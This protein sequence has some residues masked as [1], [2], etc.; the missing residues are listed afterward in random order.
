MKTKPEQLQRQLSGAPHPVYMVVGDEPL[1]Q[2]ESADMIRGFLLG[3]GYSEREVMHVEASFDWNT[4]LESGNALSLFAEKKIIELRLPQAKL[5][6]KASEALTAYLENPSPDNTLVIIAGKL[7]SAAKK[8]AWFKRIDTMGLIVEIWPVELNQLD[9]WIQKRAQSLG[10]SLEQDAIALLSDRVEGNLLAAKQEL[11]KLNL[12]YPNQTLSSDHIVDAVSDSSRYD[13]YGLTEAALMGD[14]QRCQKVIHVLQQDG[15]E[16]PIVLWA[17][18][19]ELR[20]LSALATGIAQGLAAD[21][22]FQRERVWGKRK[23]QLSNANRRLNKS[24]IE[25]LLLDCGQV[26]KMIKGQALGQ[27]WL[28]ISEI[29]LQLA[30]LSLPKLLS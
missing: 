13:I 18:A 16:A 2:E 4:L 26:D 15:T 30:G 25:Q 6:K 3:Q 28:H 9:G 10:L 20:A 24:Q 5:N 7:E 19:R 29:C 11:E 1:L 12:L 14:I 27:P 21:A 17:I 22:V 8:T 23:T